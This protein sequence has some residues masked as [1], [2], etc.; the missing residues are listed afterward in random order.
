MIGIL[1]IGFGNIK[2]VKNCVSVSKKKKKKIIYIK[3]KSHIKRCNRIIIPGHGFFKN[4]LD[5]LKKIDI[6]NNILNTEKKKVKILGI[7]IGLQMFCLLNE[8]GFTNGFGLIPKKIKKFKPEKRFNIPNIGWNNVKIIK[9]NKLLKSKNE[10]FYFAHSYYLEPCK[11]TVGISKGINNYFSSL[12]IKDNFFLTQFHPEKSG[13][14]GIK[15]MK[16]FLK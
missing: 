15:L 9:R 7:C 10:K 8:E 4:V 16:N 13:I 12:V 1:D 3:N 2:S 11:Y 6:I 14:I 5:K